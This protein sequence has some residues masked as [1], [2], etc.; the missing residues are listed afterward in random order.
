MKLQ[1]RKE[2]DEWVN[3]SKLHT[4]KIPLFAKSSEV[5][6]KVRFLCL[7]FGVASVVPIILLMFL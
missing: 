5:T 6:P 2:C 1:A 3:E 7:I 4:L